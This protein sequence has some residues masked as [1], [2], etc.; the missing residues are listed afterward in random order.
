MSSIPRRVKFVLTAL[1]IYLAVL[2]G[3]TVP[4]HAAFHLEYETDQPAFKVRPLVPAS[5]V[6]QAAE[7]G[8][9][10]YQAEQARKAALAARKLETGRAPGGTVDWNCVLQK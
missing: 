6:L 3:S 5:R 8:Y 1:G 2:I 4:A 9:A 10:T 7:K